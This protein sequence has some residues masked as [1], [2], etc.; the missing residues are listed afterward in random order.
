MVYYDHIRYPILY[1]GKSLGLLCNLKKPILFDRAIYYI[2]DLQVFV[3]QLNRGIKLIFLVVKGSLAYS[4]NML[5]KE[6]VK[7][8]ATTNNAVDC[9]GGGRAQV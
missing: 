1:K 3:W 5:M 7:C 2:Y 6:R 8:Y 9:L 4:K